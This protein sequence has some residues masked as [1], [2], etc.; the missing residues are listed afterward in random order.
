MT[1]V[2][3]GRTGTYGRLAD[4]ALHVDG[5]ELT[6]LKLAVSE[7]FT[8]LSTSPRS[9]APVTEGSGRTPPTLRAA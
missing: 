8:R 5:Y 9:T 1:A 7:R 2:E 3:T 6:G 4:L